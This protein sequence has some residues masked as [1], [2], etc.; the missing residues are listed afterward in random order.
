MSLKKNTAWNLL[1]MGLPLIGAAAFIPY[2]LRQLGDEAFGVLTLIWALIGYFSLFDFGAGRALTY[3]LAKLRSNQEW[4]SVASVLRAGLFLTGI[5]GLIGAIIMLIAAPS[6]AQRWLNISPALQTDVLLAFQIAALGVIPTSVTS[7]VRGALEGMERFAAS[8]LNKIILGFCM[9]CLPALSIA[10][11]GNHLWLI[12]LYLV[13]ARLIVTVFGIW[14]L[15][16]FFRTNLLMSKE[17]AQEPPITRPM[18]SYMRGLIS[19]GFWVT[20]SGIISPLMVYGDRFFVSAVVGADQL[21]SY[22][23]PQEGLMRLLIVPI[24]LCGALLPMFTALTDIDT[25]WQSYQ[26]HFKRM[27]LIMAALCGLLAISAYPFFSW[28]ISPAFADKA[29]PITL[30]LALGTFFNAIALVPQTLLHSKGHTKITAQ[31][32]LVEA[33]LYI[34]VLY[35]LSR[36][37]GLIGAAFAWVIRV[38]VDLGLLHMASQGFY[39]KM[40]ATNA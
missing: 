40:K 21:S 31:F 27:A 18:L 26:K 4:L 3:E 10:L 28:W 36:E 24:A 9:F 8:N 39:K 16:A 38:V 13:L 2:C 17:L 25:L 20:V 30:I 32:H 7:G 19:Y 29:L 33:L 15:R 12:A 14:Q 1:G 11:H 37:F 6:L 5:T 23:I 22:A 34:A 35:F